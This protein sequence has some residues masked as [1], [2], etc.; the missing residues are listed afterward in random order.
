MSERNTDVIAAKLDV[1][2]R[3][4]AVGLTEGKPRQDQILLLSNAGLQP[5]EIAELLGTSANSVSVA[6]YQT[7]NKKTTSRGKPSA[8]KD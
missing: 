8:S 1:L 3:L 7:K 5:R 6:L 2:I 4:I